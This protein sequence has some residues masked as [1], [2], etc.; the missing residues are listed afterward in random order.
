MG[1]SAWF[2]YGTAETVMATV[3]KTERITTGSG[4]SISHK[5]LVFTTQETFEN[6]DCLWY[7]KFNSSDVQGRLTPGQYSMKVYGWR[8]PFMSRYR[9][10]VD[11]SPSR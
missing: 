7:G 6:S 10:I 2:A 1:L 11:V 9:N 5:Y 4:D 3:T 8:I